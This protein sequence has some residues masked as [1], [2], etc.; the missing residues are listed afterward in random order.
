MIREAHTP[1]Q[2][3]VL[4]QYYDEQQK[5]FLLKAAEEKQEW[6]QLSQNTTAL[7]AKYPRP[8]DAVRYQYECYTAKA[9]DARDQ[10]MRFNQLVAMASTSKAQ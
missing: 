10:S 1:E 7:A 4:A 6:I 9:S 5:Y 2:Y 8:A 3:R